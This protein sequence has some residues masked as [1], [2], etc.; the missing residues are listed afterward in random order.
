MSEKAKRCYLR[1]KNKAAVK[2]RQQPSGYRTDIV[3]QLNKGVISE[4]EA[5][6]RNKIIDD[7]KKVLNDYMKFNNTRLVQIEGSSLKR[8]TKRGGKTMFF[9]IIQQKC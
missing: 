6:Y 3:K 9:L 8:K 2:K 1:R 5:Q 4:A 7:T